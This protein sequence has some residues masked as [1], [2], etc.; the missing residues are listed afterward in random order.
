MKVNPCTTNIINVLSN[1]RSPMPDVTN[2]EL[3]DE[4]LS[5]VIGGQ[6]PAQFNV[7]RIKLINKLGSR[8]HEER[9]YPHGKCRHLFGWDGWST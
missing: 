2:R 4:E 9:Q 6:T 3:T 8:S 7:W 5:N 1:T